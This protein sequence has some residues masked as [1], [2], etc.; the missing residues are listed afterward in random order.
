MNINISRPFIRFAALPILL[1]LCLS[2]GACATPPTVTISPTALLQQAGDAITIGAPEKAVELLTQASK[3]DPA[4]KTVWV[5]LAQAHFERRDY[6]KAVSAATEALARSPDNAQARSVIFV[7]SMRMA[8][9]SLN[10]IRKD[11]PL[12]DDS[13]SEAEQLVKSLRDNLGESVL[14]PEAK[15]KVAVTHTRPK[16][17]GKADAPVTAAAPK[18]TTTA[19]N[20]P[21]GALR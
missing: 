11:T 8:V 14:I 19:S 5:K 17:S 9:N 15:A 12:S 21:F 16:P 2:L 4:D 20:D 6:P 7:S 18:V 13:K 3:L 10:D 1:V